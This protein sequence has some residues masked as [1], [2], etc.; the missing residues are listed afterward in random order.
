VCLT[1]RERTL[2]AALAAVVFVGI[3]LGCSTDPAQTVAPSVAPSVAPRVHV[4]EGGAATTTV[5]TDT[6]QRTEATQDASRGRSGAGLD[7]GS[8]RDVT[9]TSTQ[10]DTHIED[11]GLDT[12]W[13]SFMLAGKKAAALISACSMSV[14]AGLLVWLSHSK[15]SGTSFESAVWRSVGMAMVV[16]PLLL[17]T[18]ASVMAF[19]HM[20]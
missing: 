16:V 15:P 2:I 4:A 8:S 1:H 5:T 20:E 14:I 17:V 12:N 11:K 9:Q 6:R 19:C 3:V 13:L 7:V 10:G 18:I